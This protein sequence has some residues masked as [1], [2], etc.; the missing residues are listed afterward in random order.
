MLTYNVSQRTR[1]QTPPLAFGE[2]EVVTAIVIQ[3]KNA[4]SSTRAWGEGAVLTSHRTKTSLSAGIRSEGEVTIITQKKKAK[5][6]TRVS[7][8]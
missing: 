3:K 8:E 6:S 1:E 5:P 2:G 7:E 4:K